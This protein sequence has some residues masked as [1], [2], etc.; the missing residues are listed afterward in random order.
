MDGDVL[1]DHIAIP[2]D[3]AGRLLPVVLVLGRAADRRLEEDPVV[4]A[5]CRA[6]R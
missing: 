2:G 6:V 4:R 5:E 3:D 1:A